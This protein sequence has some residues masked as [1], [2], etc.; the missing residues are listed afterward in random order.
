MNRHN[1]HHAQFVNPCD[2]ISYLFKTQMTKTA[3]QRIK[4]EGEK[5]HKEDTINTHL[6]LISKVISSKKL[7]NFSFSF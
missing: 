6:L 7:F 1:N 5:P 4:D 2:V 3:N